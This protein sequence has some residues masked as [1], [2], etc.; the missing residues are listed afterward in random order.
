VPNIRS[1]IASGETEYPA[2]V[3]RA[4]RKVYDIKLI[5]D[6]LTENERQI[7]LDGCLMNYYKNQN[8]ETLG[9]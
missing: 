1:L 8:R 5:V 6:P 4:D 9:R 7:L 2:K 3:I